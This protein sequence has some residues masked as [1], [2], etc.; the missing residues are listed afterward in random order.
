VQLTVGEG[1]V[2]EAGEGIPDVR[3]AKAAEG[4]PLVF[5]LVCSG[6]APPAA[7]VQLRPAGKWG[8]GTRIELHPDPVSLGGR[9]GYVVLTGQL[10]RFVEPATYSLSAGDAARIQGDIEMIPLPIVELRLKVEPP[11]YAAVTPTTNRPAPSSV[12]LEGSSVRFTVQCTNQKSLKSVSVNSIGGSQRI[13]CVPED[14]GRQHWSTPGNLAELSD[15]RQELRYEVEVVDDDGLSP[16]LPLRGV[17]RVRPDEPPTAAIELVHRVV[18]PTAKPQVIYRAGDDYGVAG[19][20]MVVEIERGAPADA[21]RE[22]EEPMPV[23]ER[24]RPDDSARAVAVETRRLAIPF[25]DSPALGDDLPLAGAYR[26][27]LGPM[28]LAP[29]DRLRLMVEAIDYR[30]DGDAGK[31]VSE[32]R[33]LEVGDEKAV[34][35]AIREADQRS[36]TQL[37]DLIRSELSIGKQP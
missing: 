27:D 36:E 35:A 23:A 21:P 13:A 24:P 15:L 34:L 20:E 37:N 26:L 31:S 9:Q 6:L 5:Q 28:A 8:A 4:Q 3:V 29:G 10:P 22:S 17:V 1:V 32:A 25:G 14:E 33:I 7:S 30:G 19:L 12:I 11:A 16:Q 18:L 2:F